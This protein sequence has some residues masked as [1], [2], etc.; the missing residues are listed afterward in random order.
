MPR[1]DS[2]ARIADGARVADDVEIGP[3]CVIGPSVE[4]QSGVRLLAHV[5][6][7]GVTV[8][9]ERTLVYPFASLGSAPQAVSYRGEPTKLVVGAECTIR[10]SVTMNTGTQDGRGV[11]SVGDRGYFMAYS[12]VGH[13]CIVGSDVTFA[14]SATLGGHCVVGDYV[15]IGG[16]AAVHQFCRI[17]PYALVAGVT[18]VRSDLIPF[19]VAVGGFARLRGINTVGMKRRNVAASSIRAV[20]S[21]YRVLFLGKGEMPQRID[22]TQAEFGHD[23]AVAQILDFIRG[24]RDRPL[25]IPGRT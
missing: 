20:R 18:G 15:F 23:A 16:L 4:L 9:G 22:A 14:N 3:Y 13:D 5:N 8:I 19:G 25:C 24:G 10:E 6:V 2:T 1:I 11:T 21:A 12:H 17:G 7:A